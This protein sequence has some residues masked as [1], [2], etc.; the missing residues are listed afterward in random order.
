MHT[1]PFSRLPDAELDVMQALWQ[2]GEPRRPSQLL[3]A[4]HGKREWSLSTMQVLLTR[5]HEKGF[6]TLSCEKRFHYYAP[7][8]SEEAYRIGETRSFLERMHGGSIKSLVAA[9]VECDGLSADDLDEIAA[10]L[11]HAKGE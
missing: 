10:I 9:L 6:V 7:A 2:A 8:V 4:L 11:E 3:E 5:L 1:T